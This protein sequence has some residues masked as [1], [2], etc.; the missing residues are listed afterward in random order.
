MP[1]QHHLSRIE[2]KLDKLSEAVVSLAR[3]EER[4]ITLFNRLDNME[5]WQQKQDTKIETLEA[6]AQGNGHVI[7]FAERVFWIALTAGVG[8]LFFMFRNS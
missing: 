3:M 1:D 4:M 7:R 8:C 2:S 6:V 5:A